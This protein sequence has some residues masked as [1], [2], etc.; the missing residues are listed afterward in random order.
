MFNGVDVTLNARFAEGAQFSGGLSLGRT[1]TDNCIVVDSPGSTTVFS[2]GGTAG[3]T[4]TLQDARDGFCQVTPP[5]SA[6]TQVKFLVVYPL[7]WGVQTSAI[8]QTGPGIPITASHVVTNAAIA[9]SLG[10]NLAACGNRLPC[11]ANNEI[12]LIPDQTMFEP[13]YQQLDLRFSRM[14]GLAGT[15]RLRG[16]LDLHNIFNASDVLSLNTRY[17]DVWQNPIAILGGR[18]LKLSAQFDF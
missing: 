6:G 2:P 3:T 17:G 18:L 7:P 14:F 9:P 12:A 13:R 4:G 16:N 10:R 5:W 1:V 11:T 15:A 8:Y